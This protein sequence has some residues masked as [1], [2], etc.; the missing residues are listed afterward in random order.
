MRM[1]HYQ[2]WYNYIV[3]YF[4]Y[5]SRLIN[6][7]L[8]RL[9]WKNSLFG[10]GKKIFKKWNVAAHRGKMVNWMVI[11]P[12]H[13]SRCSDCNPITPCARNAYWLEKLCHQ[14]SLD[15]QPL[16]CCGDLFVK[17]KVNRFRQI[18][19]DALFFDQNWICPRA[20]L[21]CQKGSVWNLEQPSLDW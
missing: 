7:C 6:V 17:K 10:I 1:N 9:K 20:L 16:F 11:A 3:K 21:K 4:D 5:A 18:Q 19:R 14:P 12:S 13:A 8:K 2:I 15:C